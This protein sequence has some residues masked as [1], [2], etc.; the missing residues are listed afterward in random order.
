MV[1]C[2]EACSQICYSK[3]CILN[4]RYSPIGVCFLIANKLVGIP[5]LGEILISL[6]YYM[7]TV[8]VGLFIHGLIV[9]PLIYFVFTR[10]NPFRYMKGVIQ[11]YVTAFATASRCAYIKG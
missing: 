11:A 10:K 2:V 3:A 4:F 7:L 1:K 8:L 9:I 6:G 5:D